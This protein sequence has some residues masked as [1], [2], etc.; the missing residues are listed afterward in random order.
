[1]K[2]SS[3]SDLRRCA[4]VCLARHA[5]FDTGRLAGSIETLPARL[6]LRVPC[7][8]RPCPLRSFSAEWYPSYSA[9]RT[10]SL[11]TIAVFHLATGNEPAPMFIGD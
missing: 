1:M 9:S 7:E 10:G 6:S 2:V 4:C 8:R 11:R 5:Y 3:E